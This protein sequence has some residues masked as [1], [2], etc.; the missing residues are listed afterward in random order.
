MIHL[1]SHEML[2][3]P[4]HVSFPIPKLLNQKH[5]ILQSK[6]HTTTMSGNGSTASGKGGK[7][8]SKAPRKAPAKQK[9]DAAKTHRKKRRVETYSSYLYKVEGGRASPFQTPGC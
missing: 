8:A 3:S 4:S 2:F 9:K 5:I 1:S 6:I 7:G